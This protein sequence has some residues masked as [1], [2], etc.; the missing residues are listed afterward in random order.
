VA[1]GDSPAPGELAA[2]LAATLGDPELALL[3]AR[4]DGAG[5]IDGDGR[6]AEPPAGD[7]RETTLVVAGERPLAAIVHRPGLL[8]DPGQTAEIARAARL[9]LEHERLGALRRAHLRRLQAS[10]ARIVAASDAQRLA[11]E[12]DLHDGAQQRLV[13]LAIDVRLARRTLGA[14]DAELERELGAAEEELRGALAEL[15]ELAHGLFPS[16]LADEGLAAALE[17][18]AE[19][20]PRLRSG[21][22]PDERFAAPV[23]SAAYFVIAEALRRSATGTVRLG[24]R[25]SDGVLVLDIEAEHEPDGSRTPVEDRV[26]ALGGTLAADGRRLHVEL[27]CA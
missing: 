24:A 12:R 22:L 11:L 8:A 10:R 17:V 27:P 1:L 21:A 2:Q 5:W 26:G 15:R 19:Q 7:A 18:L 13:T 20:E 23:E 3:H 16:V 25:R 4:D 6:A 9:A 14:D